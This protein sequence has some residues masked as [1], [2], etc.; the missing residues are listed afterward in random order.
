M[1]MKT[2]RANDRFF[3]STACLSS[4]GSIIRSSSDVITSPFYPDFY[5]NNQE[6]TWLVSAPE[7]QAISFGFKSFDLIQ[8]G[9]YVEVRDGITEHAVV[10]KNST[11]KPK[12]FHWW[13]SRGQ[14][15][16]VKFKSDQQIVGKGFEMNFT[17]VEEADQVS[18]CKY[19]FLQTK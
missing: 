18:N 19:I 17:F 10:L 4:S 6:C 11:S 16:W 7:H 1:K 3:W 13:T 2:V 12:L 8:P 14:Y 15:L 5:P 9:D